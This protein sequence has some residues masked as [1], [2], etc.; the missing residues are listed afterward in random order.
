MSD[1]PHTV[2]RW[3]IDRTLIDFMNA[4]GSA[5]DVAKAIERMIDA[6]LANYLRITPTREAPAEPQ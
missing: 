1:D 3:L 6:K 5:E 2:D 4:G